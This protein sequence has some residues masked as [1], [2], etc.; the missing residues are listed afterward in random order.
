MGGSTSAGSSLSDRPALATNAATESATVAIQKARA[1]RRAAASEEM[2]RIAR[3]AA[4]DAMA[5]AAKKTRVEI[6]AACRG[7]CRAGEA[8]VSERGPVDPRRERGHERLEPRAVLVVEPVLLRCVHV[9]HP[10]Q[11]AA[12]DDRHHDLRARRLV[13]G[14]VAGEGEDVRHDER[15]AARG[16]RPA[17]ALAEGDAHA[18][19]L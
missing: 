15:L 13:A 1:S 19:G 7:R 17:D 10:A 8:P 11:L 9:E 18:R 3:Y 4:V 12:R 6:T 2:P 5:Q 16:G 14:D